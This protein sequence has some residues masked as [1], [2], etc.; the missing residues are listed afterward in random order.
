M[1]VPVTGGAGYIG[2]HVAL[3]LLEQGETVVV[4]DNLSSEFRW[5]VPAQAI[6]AVLGQAS[7]SVDALFVSRLLYKLPFFELCLKE[8]CA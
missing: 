8:R 4:L 5:L 3:A 1:P 2:S 7:A 6:F